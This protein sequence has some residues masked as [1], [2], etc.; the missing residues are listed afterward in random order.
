MYDLESFEAV[1]HLQWCTHPVWIT[2]FHFQ[3]ILGRLALVVLESGDTG[4]QD[5]MYEGRKED[6]RGQRESEH[7]GRFVGSQQQLASQGGIELA[8]DFDEGSTKPF[9]R[10]PED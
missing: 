9:V 1:F 4:P 10:S 5:S 2:V 7:I 6:D 3:S 8:S